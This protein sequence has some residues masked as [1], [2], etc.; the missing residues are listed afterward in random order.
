MTLLLVVIQGL[1]ASD[2]QTRL[3]DGFE[4]ETSGRG[5]GV[6]WAPQEEVL[7]HAAVAGFWTHGGWNSTTESVC[8]GVPMLCRPHF[9]DQMGNARYVEHVWRVGFEVAG[10]LES[11][12]RG[13]R[14]PAARH[15]ERGSGD[16]GQGQGPGGDGLGHRRIHV[17]FGSLACMLSHRGG[18]A[19]TP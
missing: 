17:S 1:V 6:E 14:H 2:V 15:R 19:K 8:E 16:A 13:G 5:M 9:G 11:W 7:R 12:R 4:A 18:F 10:A 3:P